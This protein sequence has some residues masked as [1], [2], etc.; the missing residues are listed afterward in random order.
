MKKWILAPSWTNL[1]VSNLQARFMK[2]FTTSSPLFCRRSDR[3]VSLLT[4]FILSCFLFSQQLKSEGI[5]PLLSIWELLQFHQRCWLTSIITDKIILVIILLK[6]DVSPFVRRRIRRWSYIRRR[7]ARIKYPNERTASR[8][9]LWLSSKV[10]V[11]LFL[12]MVNGNGAA[13]CL[14]QPLN[15]GPC[16]LQLS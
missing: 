8:R 1:K 13:A 16:Q 10:C 9:A 12:C 6:R 3:K 15:G 4:L 7:L 2:R 5:P 14:C 11:F